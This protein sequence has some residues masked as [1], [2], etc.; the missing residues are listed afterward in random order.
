MDYFVLGTTFRQF[1][2][3]ALL[4][5]QQSCCLNLIGFLPIQFHSFLPKYYKLI[6]R[7]SLP[8]DISAQPEYCGVPNDVHSPFV[9]TIYQNENRPSGELRRSWSSNHIGDNSVLVNV[10]WEHGRQ[11]CAEYSKGELNRVCWEINDFY[12]MTCYLFG[13][14]RAA[15][16]MLACL[17]TSFLFLVIF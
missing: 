15:R 6:Y 5:A 13:E 2:K 10:D 4:P 11:V 3:C 17:A 8:D 1:P 7:P 12:L 16:L 9:R 14:D